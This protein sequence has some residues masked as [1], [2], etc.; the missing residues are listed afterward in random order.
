[1]NMMMI[2]TWMCL[3]I[4]HKRRRLTPSRYFV[5]HDLPP[6]YRSPW[7]Y[8]CRSTRDDAWILTVG[9]SRAAFSQ[10]VTIT[11]PYLQR[12]AIGHPNMQPCD[13]IGLGLMWITSRLRQKHLCQIFGQTPA[14]VC[15]ELQRARYALR[16]A[17]MH[18]NDAR[19][20]WP[21]PSEM[22]TFAAIIKAKRRIKHVFGFM[23]GV[24]FPIF[25]PNDVNVQSAYYNGWLKGVSVTNVLV[26]TPD[27]C[28]CMARTNCPG[29][30]H[31]SVTAIP[32]YRVLND[33]I[34]TPPKN[35]IIADSA[36]VRTSSC[37]TCLTMPQRLHASQHMLSTNADV[38]KTR[39]AAEWGMNTLQSTFNRLTVP[40][41]CDI[42]WNRNLLRLVFHL[43]NF[44]ARWDGNQ[45]RTVFDPDDGYDVDAESEAINHDRYLHAIFHLQ[46]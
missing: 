23:D 44:K 19:I 4:K 16:R 32:I 12:S 41:P 9:F 10:L 18:D 39:Q 26:F 37:R 45:T 8:L 7:A 33:P 29:S 21:S 27:G 31:D 30:W 5:K 11:A 24:H 38:V 13:V 25:R 22:A 28:I 46:D 42:V 17:L 35:R 36:F 1:M 6:S 14:I 34:L 2:A 3:A 20:A 43:F 15:R 40:L